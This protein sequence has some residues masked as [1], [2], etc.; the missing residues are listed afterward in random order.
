[1]DEYY[2]DEYCKQVERE[3]N[4]A[5]RRFSLSVWHKGIAKEEQNY[6]LIKDENIHI[7]LEGIA[8][9]DDTVEIDGLE[10]CKYINIRQMVESIIVFLNQNT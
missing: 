9:S 5:L 8:E 2:L 1:M 4:D 7:W 3:N 6:K 10:I